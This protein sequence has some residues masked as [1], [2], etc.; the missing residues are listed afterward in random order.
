MGVFPHRALE[1]NS[2]KMHLDEITQIA[3]KDIPSYLNSS[4]AV[5]IS[6]GEPLWQSGFLRNLLAKMQQRTIQTAVDTALNVA[7]SSIE[8]VLDHVDLWLID[9]MVMDPGIH[10]KYTGH[11]TREF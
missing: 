9:L 1:L 3:A 6:G 11:P 7:W 5:T 4:G 10:Q 2:R 8:M